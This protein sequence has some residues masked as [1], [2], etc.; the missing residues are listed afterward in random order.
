[1]YQI[2][3]FLFEWSFLLLL[4]SYLSVRRTKRANDSGLGRT[5]LLLETSGRGTR[6][7]EAGPAVSGLAAKD[8]PREQYPWLTLRGARIGR[9]GRSGEG[10]PRGVRVGRSC[11]LLATMPTHRLGGRRGDYLF[12]FTADGGASRSLSQPTLV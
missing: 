6:A 4:S 10:G 2:S 3:C 1:M 8:S 5:S 12:P 9:E 11:G 7:Q